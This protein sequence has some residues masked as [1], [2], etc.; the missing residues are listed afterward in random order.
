MTLVAAAHSA[1]R[2][3]FA[4]AQDI[5]VVRHEIVADEPGARGGDDLG[6][7]PFGLVLAGLAACTSITLQMY[8]GRKQ[9]TLGQVRVDLRLSDDQGAMRIE[10]RIRFEAPLTDEQ[11]ARLLEIAD[12]T[13]VTR[14]LKASFTIE[15]RL[16][17]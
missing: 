3:G 15:T 12:K 8:A 6:P 14:A 17:R 7:A 1:S 11:R 13:P 4:H 5:K 10:R 2:Q 16:E 9:W